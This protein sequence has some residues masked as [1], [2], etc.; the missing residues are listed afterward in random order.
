MNSDSTAAVIGASGY[1][2]AELVKILSRHPRVKLGPLFA[3]ASAGKRMDELYPV[4][5]GRVET[6]L[7]PYTAEAACTSDVVFIALPSGEAMNIVPELLKRG[8]R[9]VDLGGDFR[10][11]DAQIYQQFYKRQHTATD[12]IP[13]AV[14]GFPEWDADAIRSAK[15]VSNPGCYPTSAILSLAPLLKEGLISPKG[16][17]VNSLSGV[18]GAGRS[19]SIDHSFVEV[20]ESVKAYKVGV[21]QHSPEIE[22][23]L[24]RLSGKSVTVTFV[25]HLIP[26]TRGIYTTIYANPTAPL[27]DDIVAAAFKKYYERAPFVRILG[28][29]V[30]EIKSVAGTNYIDI[31]WKIYPE[32]GQIIVLATIDNLI[33]GAAGQAVQSMNLMFG[34]A[35]TEGL[36]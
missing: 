24:G 16:I 34:F 4:L 5:R 29:A 15:L 8:K 20:N 31:G 2:G 19:T 9:V 21:H 6:T 13:Q 17:V 14:Y 12:I 11:Q 30:P 22:T 10:F 23:A 28:P 32:N 7:R 26:I 18:S 35:E 36:Q 1:S 27:T 33:K 3:N 25:P